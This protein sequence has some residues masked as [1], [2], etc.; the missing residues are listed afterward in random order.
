MHLPLLA[1][2]IALAPLD[3]QV[4]FSDQATAPPAGY[5]RDFGEAYGPRPGGLT[6]GWV[7][8]G[9]TTPLS[10]IGN[11]RNRGTGTDPRLATLIHMQLPAGSAG[12]RTPGSWEIAV[13]SGAYRV[14]AAVGD[15]SHTDSTH[16][17]TIEDQNGTAA[18]V[19][20]AAERHRTVTRTV[21]VTDGRLT[22][23]AGGVN[24]KL[25]YVDI[26][27][28]TT[29]APSVRRTVPADRAANVPLTGAVVAD[30]RLIAGGVAVGSLTAGSATI[31]RVSDGAA[32][33][34][35]V[36]TSGGGDTISVAP[37][38]ALQPG[39]LYRL[40]I[41]GAVRD[42]AGNAFHPYS[43][44]FTTGAPPGGEAAF[45]KVV[46]GAGGAP[47]TSV[48]KGPDGRLY[49]A[50]LT[51][52]LRRYTIDA[53]GTLADELVIDTVRNA[54][55]G[56]DRTVIG[57]AFD[58]AST[59][60]APILWITDNQAYPGSDVPEWTSR[61]A[62]LS[63]QNLGTYTAV[64]T[65][66]PRSARDHETNS[67][68]FGPDGACYL[69]QG[70]MNAMGAPD[71]AWGNRPERLLSAAVL[72]LDPA[73]LPAT[74]PLDVRTEAGGGYDPYAAGAPLTLYATGVRNA[75]D[76]V[77]H[78][79]GHL[80][81]PTNGSAAG[82]NTPAT[83]SPLPASCARRGYT[84]P[85]VPAITANPQA[86]TDYV[87]DVKPGRYYGHPGDR[88]ADR[89]R[90]AT[91]PRRGPGH[92]EHLCDGAGRRAH[93]AAAAPLTGHAAG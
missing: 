55:G 72:R 6:Y 46:S 89:L 62:R 83:P 59:P 7:Q 35:N 64:V 1:V 42:T 93:H 58:P 50:T 71:A 12:I 14:T 63:G 31:R 19:P 79:N 49:A 13:P 39:T 75:Y 40:D 38:T 61:I 54:H 4:N 92:R 28:L 53:D 77:W 47:Y 36:A 30:L 85:Q 74:L 69:T 70:S 87:F 11:G 91:R 3:V 81:A 67:L 17:L 22:L 65:G 76:L 57:L 25:D 37:A 29:P 88:R 90:P 41:T 73:R 66:L 32:V 56:A 5:V 51:G 18:F 68:A 60:A 80:Y 16:W 21:T 24:T 43:M 20:S 8:N 26:T 44:V 10:L 2:L 23:P 34:V 27:E 86:E 45:D 82:G 48:V 52:Q 78:S 9:T 33:P 15:P 84:G